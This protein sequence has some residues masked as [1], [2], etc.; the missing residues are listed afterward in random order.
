MSAPIRYDLASIQAKHQELR[1]QLAVSRAA[2]ARQYEEL[3]TPP[4]AD[5]KMEYWVNQAGRAAAVYDG[6]MTGYKLFRRFRLFADMFG[7]IKNKTK[8]RKNV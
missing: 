5:N 4:V 1:K 2:I 7:K 3:T 8:K 6:V